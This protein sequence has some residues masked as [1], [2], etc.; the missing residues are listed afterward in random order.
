MEAEQWTRGVR[1]ASTS[2]APRLEVDALTTTEAIRE[3]RPAH[4]TFT[5]RA[6]GGEPSEIE[7]SAF[8]I[9][10]S[11]EGSSGAMVLFWP[12]GENGEPD[13]GEA[14]GLGSARLG[15]G[16]GAADEPLRRQHLL[17]P[18]DPRQRRGA[19]PRR[20]HRD[21]QPRPRPE[22]RAA[23]P[24]PAHPPAPRPH[25]GADVLPAL[26]PGRVGDHDLGAV[27]AR[28][29][30]RGP[31]RALHL[32]PA[33]AGRG[34]RAARARSPSATRRRPSGSSAGR[35]S[36][37]RRS[38]IAARRSATGSPTARR[39]S[40]TSPT[41]SRRSARRSRA[42]SRSGSRASTSPATPTC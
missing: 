19:D 32:G 11:E 29:L 7:A 42:S 22:R 40:P 9:V 10:A 16:A 5:I 27:L 6:A 23:D 17:R 33:L 20:G 4:A 39:R 24:H 8:P 18:A 36:A 2:T 25:P 3:G 21:P 35:R 13:R 41:T 14:Q 15:A 38:P 30:A 28:G 34:P 12:L 1:A 37:P 31:D 26:L